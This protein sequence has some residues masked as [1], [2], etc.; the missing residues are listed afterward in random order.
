MSGIPRRIPLYEDLK[1]RREEE[2]RDRETMSVVYTQR[3]VTC[4]ASCDRLGEFQGLV[5]G[6]SGDDIES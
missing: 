3:A 5:R 1:L 2:K 6:V 4:I